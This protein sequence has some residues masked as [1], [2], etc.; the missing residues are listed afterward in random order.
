[1]GTCA[2]SQTLDIKNV[3]SIEDKKVK[4]SSVYIFKYKHI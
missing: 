3:H 1:M 2:H 4:K